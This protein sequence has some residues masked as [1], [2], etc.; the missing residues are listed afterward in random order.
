MSERRETARV[1]VGFL[2]TLAAVISLIAI[3]SFA[4]GDQIL[5]AA[6]GTP[7]ICDPESLTMGT[8]ASGNINANDTGIATY[9]GQNMVIGST[10]GK[11]AKQ[12]YT[13][14]GPDQSYA[15]EAEGTTVVRGNFLAKPAKG[16]FTLGMVAFGAQYLPPSGTTI[17]TV[18]GKGEAESMEKLNPNSSAVQTWPDPDPV[19]VGIRGTNGTGAARYTYNGSIA[20]GMSN[21]WGH[22][23]DPSLPS[24]HVYNGSSGSIDS[25]GD[26]SNVVIGPV[27]GKATPSIDASQYQKHIST[28][29]NSLYL[30]TP[31]GTVTTGVAPS[32]STTYYKYDKSKSYKLN[33]T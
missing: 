26:L 11:S 31:T 27:D 32:G 7:G 14:A 3:P 10:I 8:D 12:W 20:G 2:T 1:A 5:R 30:M 17:L 33:F 18:G 29:S 16:F 22:P 15:T 6:P 24:I 9:V 19:P 13:D 23:N 28:L 21:V 4:R 25:N